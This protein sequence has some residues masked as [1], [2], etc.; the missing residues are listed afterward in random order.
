MR[1]SKEQIEQ[2]MAGHEAAVHTLVELLTPII[3]AR[4]ARILS[5]STDRRNARQETQDMTQE[6]FLC[7]FDKAGHKLRAWDPKRGLSLENFVGIIAEREVISR[8]R[9]R[10]SNPWTERPTDRPELEVHAAQDTRLEHQTNARSCLRTLLR[11]LTTDLSDTGMQ[12]FRLLYVE[13]QSVP[14][15]CDRMRMRPNA[16]YAWR[17]RLAKRVRALM[18]E[19]QAAHGTLS[20]TD[21]G[22]RA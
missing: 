9:R 7:L 13:E 17:S 4:V 8:M 6:V 10:R 18:R 3:Q 2:C 16:V 11:Q 14:E 22:A 5:R 21:Q 15:I 1:F 20:T 12:M 19:P